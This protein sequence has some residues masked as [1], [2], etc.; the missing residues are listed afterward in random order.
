MN[1]AL[2]FILIPVYTHKCDHDHCKSISVIYRLT[3][4]DDAVVYI[5]TTLFSFDGKWEDIWTK[6]F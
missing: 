1:L 6:K 5:Y 2:D 4:N 3:G